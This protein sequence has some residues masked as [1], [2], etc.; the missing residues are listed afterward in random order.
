[1]EKI[2]WMEE[3]LEE[4]LRLAAEEGHE[5]A[6]RL[7]E[8]LLYDEPGYARLHHTLGIVYFYHADK[9]EQAE[10]HLRLAI[11]FDAT[12]A[13][14]YW[15]LGKLLSDD[16]RLDEAIEVYN[17]GMKAKRARKAE[18]LTETGRAYELKKKFGMAIRHYKK[19]L[20]FSAELWKCLVIEES[21][22]RCK[23][24]KKQ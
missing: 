1:M 23:R 5:P 6:L 12:Y 21:I 8:K 20:G 7:L 4:G 13:E 3:Y 18:L 2:S 14:P 10:Q 9:P 11:Q 17:S 16:D 15:Y 22:K 24:K 19:A